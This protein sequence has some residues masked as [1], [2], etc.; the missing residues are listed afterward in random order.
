M[1]FSALGI[2]TK[3]SSYGIYSANTILIRNNYAMTFCAAAL[4]YRSP[5]WLKKGGPDGGSVSKSNWINE[6]TDT[7]IA[8]MQES[9]ASGDD[10]VG[11]G[12]GG[13][14]GVSGLPA[15]VASPVSRQRYSTEETISTMVRTC[16]FDFGKELNMAVLVFL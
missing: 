11:Y 6:V 16:C 10:A 14:D 3:Q 4:Y 7:V 12:H 2:P 9:P 13:P 5:V 15:H 8:R 1:K